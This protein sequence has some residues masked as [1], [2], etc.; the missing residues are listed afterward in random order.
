MG[1]GRASWRRR[2]AAAAVAACACA[3]VTSP[4]FAAD[5][6]EARVQ[7]GGVLD[8]RAIRSSAEQDWLHG[9]L[10]KTRYGAL[11]GSAATLFALSHAAVTLDAKASEVLTAHIHV[12]LDAEPDPAQRRARVGLVE[13]FGAWRPELTPHL[14]LRVRAGVFFPPISL[15]H[16]GTAWTTAYTLTPSAI[17]A[18]VGEEVRTTGVEVA[19]LVRGGAHEATLLGAVTSNNDPAGSLLAWRGWALHD[20]QTASFDELPFPRIRSIGP[21]RLFDRQ[22]RWV[23]PLREIDGRLGWYAGGGWR[24]TNRLDLVATYHDS[25]GVPSA[26]DGFQYAWQTKLT[27]A[28]VRLRLP[29]RTEVLSQYMDGTSRM[30]LLPDGTTMADVRFRAG[31]ALL[32]VAAGRHRWSFRIDDFEVRDRDAFR[33]EDDN[34]DDGRAYTAAW[35]LSL[36]EPARVFVE[37]LRVESTHPA[38]SDLS[39][40]P[41]AIEDQFQA[42]V[43]LTF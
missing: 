13:A 9:G 38:R 7:W 6:P 26:F 35:V 41:R 29:L 30:G 8:L 2:G 32:T 23:G 15:E 33:V 27:A 10:G 42:S 19:T 34:T 31:Y 36:G 12:N 18:W 17:N 14:R 43:R 40:S 25:R 5:E 3:L 16:P 4:A 22:A 21:G 20:R 11:D 37:W 39:L 24:I 28:G 1:K